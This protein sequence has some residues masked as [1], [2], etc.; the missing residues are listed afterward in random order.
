VNS[1]RAWRSTFTCLAFAA[2]AFGATSAEAQTRGPSPTT[3]E[4]SFM[5][6][7]LPEFGLSVFAT[8]VSMPATLTLAR[9]IG[10]SSSSIYAAG[11]PALLFAVFV[12]PVVSTATTTWVHNRKRPKSAR[13]FPTYWYGVGAQVG[14]VAGA[15]AGKAWVGDAGDLLMLSAVDG[16]VLSAAA[17]LGTEVHARRDRTVLG[18]GP[19]RSFALPRV[20]AQVVPIFRGSF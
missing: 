15:V 5:F 12:P 10:S 8:T 17:T 13:F 19:P 6:S 4:D 11:I 7:V 14:V 1:L 2:C 18:E 20:E 9:A 16:V 3:S